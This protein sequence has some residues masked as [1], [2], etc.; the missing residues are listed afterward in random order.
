MMHHCLSGRDP[1]S[2]APF[3][4]PPLRKLCPDINP[5]LAEV[6]DQALVY[7]IERRTPSAAELYRQLAEIKAALNGVPAHP[8]SAAAHPV[9]PPLR[10]TLG[11]QAVPQLNLPLGKAP[12]AA[13]SPPPPHPQ[14]PAQTPT[15]V[16]G[17]DEILCPQC[18]RRIPADSRFCSFC[19]A[20]L[21]HILGPARRVADPDALTR[22]F[23]EPAADGAGMRRS[24]PIARKR[25]P[26]V[27]PII[28]LIVFLMA[29]YI[30]IRI[31]AYMAQP[32]P[33]TTSGEASPASSGGEP[34]FGSIRLAALRQ[35][36]DS[37]GYNNVQFKMDGNTIVLWGTVPTIADRLM[38][39]STVYTIGNIFSIED[40]IKTQDSL[41]GP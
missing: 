5:A 1:A 25:N 2:E 27:T 29:G 8:A 9:T 13:P 14:S 6:V 37:E 30:A 17:T 15:I 24:E 12:P 35:A 22:V 31:Y 19:A 23:Q 36:L 38:V 21:A 7:D 18:R 3:S 41:A 4:F 39:Q 11:P 40:H 28:A 32:P 16:L 10:L 33:D 34:L 26:L 20:D